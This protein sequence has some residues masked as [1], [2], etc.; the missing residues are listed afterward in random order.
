[1]AKYLYLF[2]SLI[3]FAVWL[4]LFMHRRDL[5]Y[6]IIYVSILFG[7]GGLVSQTT[8]IIDWWRPLNV[9]GTSVSVEDFIIGFSIGGIAA[10]IYEEIYRKRFRKRRIKIKD[11]GNPVIFILSFSLLY[12]FLYYVLQMGSFYSSILAYLISLAYILSVRTDLFADSIFSGLFMLFIGS[13]IYYLLIFIYPTFIKDFW[14]LREAWYTRLYFGVPLGEYIW[15][16]FTGA[17]IG[18]LYEFVNKR[19]LIWQ[20]VSFLI[21]YTYLIDFNLDKSAAGGL[22][23]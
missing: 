10:V 20:V 1:M 5:R 6:E 8:N 19:K 2:W 3:F 12:L 11:P 13:A 7:F 9:L 14:Y 22:V 21:I 17:F 18:P 16:F 15:F 4:V 23:S